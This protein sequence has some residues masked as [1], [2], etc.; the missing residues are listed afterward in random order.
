MTN[1]FGKLP[2]LICTYHKLINV[3][4]IISK[5]T[6]DSNLICSVINRCYIEYFTSSKTVFRKIYKYKIIFGSESNEKIYDL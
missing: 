1:T 2:E 3:F 6:S 4:T 5:L